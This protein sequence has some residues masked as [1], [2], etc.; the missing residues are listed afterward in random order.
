MA[1]PDEAR[2]GAITRRGRAEQMFPALTSAQI[3]RVA[4]HGHRREV[5]AGELLFDVGQT[6]VPFCVV[7]SGRVEI[8]RPA[9]TGDTVI[10]THGPGEFT[11]E[12]NMLSGRRTLVRAR[13]VEDGTV[14]ELDRDG[15]LSLVQ[16]D[17][18]LS[19]IIMRAFILR[20]VELIA[21][22][23]GDVVVVGSAHCAGTLRVREFLTRNGH[24]YTSID[25][26]HDDGVQA[27]LD[28]FAVKRRGCP[29]ADLPR[30]CGAAQPD[31]SRDRGLPRVQR[32]DRRDQDP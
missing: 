25:L 27:L 26:D 23:L 17:A 3:A 24:P 31:Q 11:G 28:R 32:R 7:T 20:R 21:N 22:G 9:V 18:E 15:L 30:R 16:T 13:V 14:I 10:T 5:A 8:L 6:V 29:G 19:E 1:M 12:V 4:L 2:S